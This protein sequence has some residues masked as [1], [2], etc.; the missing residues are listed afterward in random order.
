MLDIITQITT[1]M[2][3]SRQNRPFFFDLSLSLG[4]RNTTHKFEPLTL[5]PTLLH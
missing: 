1:Q 5:I 4:Q 3:P 2:T